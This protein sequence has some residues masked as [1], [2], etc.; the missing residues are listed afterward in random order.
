MCG[1]NRAMS[2][3]ADV[4]VDVQTCPITQDEIRI[5]IRL[6]GATFD[7]VAILMLLEQQGVQATHPYDRQSFTREELKLIYTTALTGC[8]QTLIEQGWLLPSAF[9]SS[10]HAQDGTPPAPVHSQNVQQQPQRSDRYELRL[11]L[12][13][14][15][16]SM[17]AY[18]LCVF[19]S[20][21]ILSVC[22]IL[23]YV[24]KT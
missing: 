3:A 10:I 1:S 21:A 15:V 16:C 6:R 4:S 23:L 13:D 18:E 12:G 8:P 22:V 7:V 19:A 14:R 20:I 9:L 11:R 17:T 5:P 24:N 2:S